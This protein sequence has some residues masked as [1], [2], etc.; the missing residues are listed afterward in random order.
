[1]NIIKFRRVLLEELWSLYQFLFLF[2]PGR[3][4]H[5]IRGLFLGFFIKKCGHSFS[6]KENVEIHHPESLE[7]GDFSGF[8][9]N[10]IIDAIGGISIGSNVR[11]GPNVMIATMNHATK[12]KVIGQSEKV[13]KKVT[14]GNNVWVGHG[15]TILPGVMIG[16]NVIVAA[17]AVVTK[18][19]DGDCTIA[20][21]PA[22]VIG[23]DK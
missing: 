22:K 6:V 12:G 15:V 1:M 19:F 11:L 10:N 20:G 16:N 4:G 14:I 23:N 2:I 18:S 17:G 7:V 9:R 8:G 21:V 3:F 13:F 5:K